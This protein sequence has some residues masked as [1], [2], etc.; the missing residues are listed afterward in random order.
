MSRA[1][2]LGVF[3]SKEE[4]L[5]TLTIVLPP[6]IPRID[7]LGWLEGTDQLFCVISVAYLS[8]ELSRTV[9]EKY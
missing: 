4:S 9:L 5:D 8:I 7:L 6:F 2:R 3:H 1:E